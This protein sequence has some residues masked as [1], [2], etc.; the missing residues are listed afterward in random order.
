M[1]S[2]NR[3]RARNFESIQ[4]LIMNFGTPERVYV[5]DSPTKDVA[6]AQDV[7]M[8]DVYAKYGRAQHTEAYALLREVTWS[9]ADV[10]R[11]KRIGEREVQP[12]T[13]LDID[14]GQ[15]LEHFRYGDW[16]G[17]RRA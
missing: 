13:I 6:M 14:F 3:F 4:R 16:N 2:L 15:M 1:I 10:E 5:G 11:E 12:S 7:G 9:D 8:S 17:Q